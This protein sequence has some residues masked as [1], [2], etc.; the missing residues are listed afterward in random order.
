MCGC[1]CGCGCTCR[2]M[3]GMHEIGGWGKRWNEEDAAPRRAGGLR[4]D[5]MMRLRDT[6]RVESRRPGSCSIPPFIE[7]PYAC[8]LLVCGPN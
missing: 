7:G 4:G 1:G 6:P 8:T 2:G 5:G 3:K